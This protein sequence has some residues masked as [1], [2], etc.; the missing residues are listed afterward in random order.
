MWKWQAYLRKGFVLGSM[1]EMVLAL[2]LLMAMAMV[3][4]LVTVPVETVEA[5]ESRQYC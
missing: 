3:I 5:D 4:V 1:V 2:I